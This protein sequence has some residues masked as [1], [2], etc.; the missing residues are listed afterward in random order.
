MRQRRL[1]KQLKRLRDL[2]CIECLQILNLDSF[3][4]RRIKT[5]LR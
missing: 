4:L 1:T 3:E 2:L 5:V